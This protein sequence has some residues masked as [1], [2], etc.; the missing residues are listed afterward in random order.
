MEREYAR[1]YA[2]IG[3]GT[4]IWSPLAS[5]LLTGKYK[6]GIPA[7]SRAAVKGYE[8]IAERVTDPPKSPPS[9]AAP[10]RQRSRLHDLAARAG[11]VPQEPERIHR[12]HR[13]FTG[14]PVHE[15]MKALDVAPKLTAEVVKAIEAA[16]AVQW[17]RADGGST[18]GIPGG[19]HA[20]RAAEAA[21]P[22]SLVCCSSVTLTHHNR[23]FIRLTDRGD[24]QSTLAETR[25]HLGLMPFSAISTSGHFYLEAHSQ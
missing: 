2:D 24:V 22:S 8:W 25:L 7:D 21:S 15:N 3:L 9:K 14:Q 18:P 17:R 13:R 4:T 23:S 11:V 16:T 1:L 6:D 10:D 20:Q 12:H 19:V 5:G